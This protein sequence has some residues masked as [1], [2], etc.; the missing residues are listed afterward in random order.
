MDANME[1]RIRWLAWLDWFE[2]EWFPAFEAAQTWGDA[3]SRGRGGAWSWEGRTWHT[4]FHNVED[5]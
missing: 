5:V 3:W 2:Q 4:S 1:F